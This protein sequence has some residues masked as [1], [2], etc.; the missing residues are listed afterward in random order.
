MADQTT[1][2]EPIL[3]VTPE[4]AR[5]LL[6]LRAEEDEAQGLA[7]RI[8]VTGVAGNT[9]GYEVYFEAL[10]DR[11][12]DDVVFESSGLP[13]MIPAGDVDKLAN[14]TLELGDDGLSLV[15]P[16][17]PP[18]IPDGGGAPLPDDVPDADMDSDL[19]LRV[20]QFLEAQI[21]PQIASHGGM[22]RL[23]GFEAGVAYLQLGGG[24]Q[25]CGMAAMTLERGIKEAIFT[26]F[27]SEVVDVVDVTDHTSGSNPYYQA[28]K[29]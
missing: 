28:S 12:D 5:M 8:E 14:A 18:G 19:A 1:G 2:T 4:A 23:V 17:R 11:T 24:C 15:N 3:T 6:D 10:S 29:K 20:M 7:L 9:F 16:N 22:A 21:N 27:E 13:V 25:G 26:V